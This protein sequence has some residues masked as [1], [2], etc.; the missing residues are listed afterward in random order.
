[1]GERAVNLPLLRALLGLGEHTPFECVG[2][3]AEARL[4]LAR[5]PARG[6]QLAALAAAIG[7]LDVAALARPLVAV[8]DRHGM[9]A[10]VA[11]RILPLLHEAAGAAARRLFEKVVK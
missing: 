8:G 10:H 7:P 9:P 5:V 11:D 4:A 1:L 6:P 2:S 3:V